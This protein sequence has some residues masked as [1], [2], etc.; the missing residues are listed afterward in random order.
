[1]ILRV[2]PR[3]PDPAVLAQALAILRQGDVVAVPTD[4][5]YGLAADATNEAAVERVI[6]LKRRPADLAIPVIAAD[7]G[8]VERQVGVLTPLARRLITA[9]W[10]GPLALVIEAHPNLAS[11]LHR[12]SRRIAVRVPNQPVA[13]ELARMAGVPLT[14]T[15]ANLSGQAPAVDAAGVVAIFG[16]ALRAVVD[17][18]PAPG[19]PPSTIVDVSGP[20]PVLVR[21]GAVPWDRITAVVD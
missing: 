5:L 15:S 7:V 4:T 18:G 16:A 3:A 12:G 19:G 21:A 13:C 10:P 8:Q 11:A 2:D 6:A 17:G 20:A 1:M 14:A 9:F